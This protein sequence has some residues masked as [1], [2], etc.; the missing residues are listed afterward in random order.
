ME[1]W[2]EAA[3]AAQGKPQGGPLMPWEEAAQA[4]QPR[5]GFVERMGNDI[6][7]RVGAVKQADQAYLSG[8]QSLPES[9]GQIM[10]NGGAGLV[11]DLVGNAAISGYH[12]LVDEGS[13][14]DQGM[15]AAGRA[16]APA[17]QYVGEKLD[18]VAPEGG[19]ARRNLDAAGNAIGLGTMFMPIGQGGSAA[20]RAA[21]AGEAAV[22][23]APGAAKAAAEAAGGVP[24][25]LK[26]A[27]S[28]AEI[29]SADL[30]R[31]EAHKAYDF[32]DNVGGVIA[33]HARDQFLDTISTLHP[34]SAEVPLDKGY[35]GVL[36][37]MNSRRGQPLTLQGA[38]DIDMHLGDL[39]N[40]EVMNNG[41]LSAAGRKYADLQSALREYTRNPDPANLIGGAEGFQA[42]QEGQRLWQKQAQLRDVES[43]FNKADTADNP[44]RVIK[45]GFERLNNDPKRLNGYSD[46]AKALI[47]KA[48]TSSMAGDI[49]NTF[50]SKLLGIIGAGVHGVPGAIFGEAASLASRGAGEALQVS[51]ANKVAR[52]IAKDYQ[53]NAPNVPPAA[54]LK[55]LPAPGGAPGFYVDSMG[56]V[57]RTPN[58]AQEIVA[59]GAPREI[60]GAP[61]D[62]AQAAE[63]GQGQFLLPDPAAFS[64]M[65]V[66]RLGN[67]IP[68]QPGS[69][70]VGTGGL[71]SPE[72]L[73][74]M[75]PED[76]LKYLNS[77][78]RK[79]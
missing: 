75:K 25:A 69:G 3:A 62:P 19:R 63:M 78:K 56:N 47:R 50:S 37:F 51:K 39:V 35:Q 26:R 2:E 23:A 45:R 8:Q 61:V 16:I 21:G 17:A 42:W 53:F 66:D 43:I 59:G 28:A 31:G 71:I 79:K 29:P 77:L 48:A 6:N 65:Q 10:M 67:V 70:V 64:E 41:K 13:L 30:V 72:E 60:R 1:P 68:K 20:A 11:N 27:V 76:A 38:Q 58:P 22:K 12:A 4:M 54:P 5:T 73:G 7:K 34:Q 14:A 18:E 33:P 9:V 36:E 57:S 55:Q 44:A 40:S 46:E 24:G 49:L 52:E 74:R 32:A 15:K